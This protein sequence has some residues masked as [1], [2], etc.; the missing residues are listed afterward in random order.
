MLRSLLII[1]LLLATFPIL[2]AQPIPACTDDPY[3]QLLDFWVGE[4]EVFDQ[5]GRKVGIN[6]IEKVMDGCAVM[7]YWTD[8][9]GGQG[10][11]LFY[12]HNDGPLWKQVWV[13]PQA[14]APWGQKEKSLIETLP[15]GSLRFQG[16]YQM[17]ETWILDR[18]TLTPNEDGSV[19][20]TIERSRDEGKTW[21]P[22]FVGVYRK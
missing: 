13:T 9:R 10:I 6:R 17:Q 4:W 2:Q 16:T 8:I 14:K 20:Q 5:A 3:Y 19:T 21:Q 12:V 7:E 11:S 15:D 1:S 18:T 22:G